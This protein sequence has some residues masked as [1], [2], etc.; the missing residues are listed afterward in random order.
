MKRILFLIIT[1]I[2]QTLLAAKIKVDDSISQAWGTGSLQACYSHNFS[3]GCIG[4]SKNNNCQRCTLHNEHNDESV[5]LLMMARQINE[6]GALFCP[7]QAEGANN[8][9]QAWTEYR[10]PNGQQTCIWLCKD[11]YSGDQCQTSPDTP[12]TLCDIQSFSRTKYSSVSTRK[13]GSNIEDAIPFFELNQ[14]H[15]CD[16][17]KKQEHDIGLVINKWLPSGNGAF[18]RKMVIHAYRSD[19]KNSC[20]SV[21]PASTSHDI[22]VCK[23]GYKPNG[24]GTDCEPID[25]SL[26][27]ATRAAN[28]LCPG[29]DLSKYDET[30]HT[31]ITQPTRKIM[32][33]Q[34]Q[35]YQYTCTAANH[36][37]ASDTDHNC[38]ECATTPRNGI[39]P[40]NGTCVKCPTGK[41]FNA[42][43]ADNNY[44]ATAIMLSRSDLIYGKGKNRNSTQEHTDQCW[45][46]ST[47]EE[48]KKC[49]LNTSD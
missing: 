20:A 42:E 44:C 48:Y 31:L 39:H 15:K 26:C 36:A 23:N 30:K 46:K 37:F 45:T 22:L 29:W 1:L 17:L 47:P 8:N 13:N 25:P 19:K 6:H 24:T 40:E 4:Q 10:D 27:T 43:D 5:M 14:Y 38:I 35:C 16:G 9:K 49:V 32:G 2:P 3:E 41:I 18:A 7:T 33:I 28:N 34:H 21:Y 11:G 12:A